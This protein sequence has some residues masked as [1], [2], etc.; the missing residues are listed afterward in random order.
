MIASYWPDVD[1]PSVSRM[2]WRRVAVVVSSDWTAW[3]RP[4]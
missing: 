3:S 2:M 4:A 1:Q